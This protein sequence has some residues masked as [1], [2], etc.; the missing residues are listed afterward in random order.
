MSETTPTSSNQSSP[1]RTPPILGAEY[2]DDMEYQFTR[3]SHYHAPDEIT[4][5]TSKDP[6]PLSTLEN[7]KK[8]GLL[9]AVKGEVTTSSS[10]GVRGDESSVRVTDDSEPVFFGRAGLLCAA[11]LGGGGSNRSAGAG[12]DR[13]FRVRFFIVL[14]INVR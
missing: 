7:T 1:L 9:S 2:E 11:H 8:A 3:L 12:G 14:T 6:A 10:G 13:N 4:E 5:S